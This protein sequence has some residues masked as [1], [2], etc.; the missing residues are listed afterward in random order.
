MQKNISKTY[1]R[2]NF[3]FL[4]FLD[5]R[6][7]KGTSNDILHIK[8]ISQG[9]HKP[10]QRELE[11]RIIEVWTQNWRY[12]IWHF[13]WAWKVNGFFSCWCIRNYPHILMLLSLYYYMHTNWC[14][15]HG[16][17]SG[18]NVFFRIFYRRSV[19]YDFILTLS[20]M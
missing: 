3:D 14:H 12:W 1:K 18:I 6:N 8:Y 4:N 16:I 5:F 10:Q 20:V 11:I 7:Q 17:R 2:R 15:F 9:I 13:V 19:G